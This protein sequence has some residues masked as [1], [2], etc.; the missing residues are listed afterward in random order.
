MVKYLLPLSL[1]FL[2]AACKHGYCD[3]YVVFP[4]TTPSSENFAVP[5]SDRKLVLYLVRSVITRTQGRFVFSDYT[6]FVDDPD[7]LALY[8]YRG[9]GDSYMSVGIYTYKGTVIVELGGRK[10]GAF[11]SRMNHSIYSELRE[12]CQAAKSGDY[13]HNQT[14]SE[15][16]RQILSAP[17]EEFPAGNIL[18]SGH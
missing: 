17:V 6:K 14:L 5:D 7:V 18:P 10:A 16:C 3:R 1:L 4:S 15:K 8:I 2:L 13:T 12:N 9:A 11:Y